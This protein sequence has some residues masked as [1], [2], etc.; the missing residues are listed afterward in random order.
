MWAGVHGAVCSCELDAP[1]TDQVEDG[2]DLWVNDIK[3]GV[4]ATR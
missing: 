1:A 2:S 4:G 3:G